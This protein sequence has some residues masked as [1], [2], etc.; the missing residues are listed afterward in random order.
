MSENNDL[1]RA[2][3]AD[4]LSQAEPVPVSSLRAS[5]PS[6]IAEQVLSMGRVEWGATAELDDAGHLEHLASSLRL[7]R[8]HFNYADVPIAM[9]GLY[10]AGTETVLCHTGTS[11][12]SGANAQA[13]MGAWNLLHDV[14]AQ[15]M[16][17]SEDAQAAEAEGLQ[18][19]PK[20]APEES[21]HAH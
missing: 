21:S 5:I 18:P 1:G 12:N 13:L 11:P 17:L 14:C 6:A 15:G 3:E 7:T 16:Q 20:D 8:E 10:L 2:A 9:H 4:G 19:D